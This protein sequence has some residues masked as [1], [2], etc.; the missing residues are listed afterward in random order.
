M[1]K[2]NSNGKKTTFPPFDSSDYCVLNDNKYA[3]T[4]TVIMTKA[5]YEAFRIMQEK[6]C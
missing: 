3:T 1:E 4:K 6:K 5:S 2:P